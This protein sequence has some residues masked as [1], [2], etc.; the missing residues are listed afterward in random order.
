M[1][2]RLSFLII[3]YILP[4]KYCS[5]VDLSYAY[6]FH[7]RV[8][9]IVEFPSEVNPIFT[10][11]QMENRKPPS[12]STKRNS[13]PIELSATTDKIDPREMQGVKPA[14]GPK[15]TLLQFPDSTFAYVPASSVPPSSVSHS[16]S[17]YR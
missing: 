9:L 11:L 8:S 3:F 4:L 6:F 15:P 5:S 2:Q 13:E 12:S 7:M 16:P 1:F 14:V 10:Y 17:F